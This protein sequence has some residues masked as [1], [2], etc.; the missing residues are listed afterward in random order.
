MTMVPGNDRQSGH[1]A[2]HEVLAAQVMFNAS[3]CGMYLIFFKSHD[4]TVMYARIM[5]MHDCMQ[6]C[7]LNAFETTLRELES[8]A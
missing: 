3:I 4:E 7:R 5:R 8:I 6:S 1:F 2:A